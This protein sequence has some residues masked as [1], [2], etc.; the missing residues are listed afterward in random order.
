ML[1]RLAQANLF[2]V[3]LDNERRWYRYHRLFAAL[4]CSRLAMPVWLRGRPDG[5]PAAAI[6]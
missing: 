1:E 4:L 6:T 2:I 5:T 3:P